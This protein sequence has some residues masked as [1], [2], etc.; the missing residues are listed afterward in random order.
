MATKLRYG[1]CSAKR[2][3]VR[4]PPPPALPTGGRQGVDPPRSVHSGKTNKQDGHGA[5]CGRG[6]RGRTPGRWRARPDDQTGQHHPGGRVVVEGGRLPWARFLLTGVPAGNQPRRRRP[7]PAA[8]RC[9]SRWR[10]AAVSRQSGRSPTCGFNESR[11]EV[12]A[13]VRRRLD[14]RH[15][16]SRRP[17]VSGRAA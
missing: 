1:P 17:R 7:R 3:A 8:T 10:S 5:Q 15:P 16:G 4:P 14:H 12:A 9:S 11:S 2:L 6:H 13:L